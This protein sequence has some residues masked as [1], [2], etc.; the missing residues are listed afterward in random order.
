MSIY[1]AQRNRHAAYALWPYS[2]RCFLFLLWND[3][4]AENVHELASF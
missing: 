1:R 4:H 3:A 2:V